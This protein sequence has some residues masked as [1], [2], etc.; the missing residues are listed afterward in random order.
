[1]RTYR[2]WLPT[3]LPVPKPAPVY[4]FGDDDSSDDYDWNEEE[5]GVETQSSDVDCRAET[6]V[7]SRSEDDVPVYCG[8][9]GYIRVA[10]TDDEDSGD[11]ADFEGGEDEFVVHGAESDPESQSEEEEEEDGGSNGDSDSD[12]E[13][14]DDEQENSAGEPSGEEEGDESDDEEGAEFGGAEGSGYSG[15]K[16]ADYDD[17]YDSYD[18]SDGEDW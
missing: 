11:D 13:A 9:S 6:V 7:E 17:Y 5:D 4:Y 18:P 1:M 3:R 10:Y 14:A 16:G 2:E 8:R 12:E 15:D